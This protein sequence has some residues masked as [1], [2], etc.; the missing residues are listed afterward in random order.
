MMDG[1]EVHWVA[2]FS[3]QESRNN[4]LKTNNE[5]GWEGG[6]LRLEANMQREWDHRGKHCACETHSTWCLLLKA[7][8]SKPPVT[9]NPR[10]MDR[11][12]EKRGANVDAS[13]TGTWKGLH[14]WEPSAVLCMV[15][16]AAAPGSCTGQK[17][18]MV[19]LMEP[20]VYVPMR[21]R[22]TYREQWSG[23]CEAPGFATAAHLV[24]WEQKQLTW[25]F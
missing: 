10:L 25:P 23:M 4:L 2:Q 14:L 3:L 13:G 19:S 21:L 12:T 20:S 15:W 5:L 17:S 11:H 16:A 24:L 18:R 6:K 7:M 8:E 22:R 9:V 1:V